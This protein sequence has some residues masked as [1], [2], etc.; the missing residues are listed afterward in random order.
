MK[1]QIIKIIVVYFLCGWVG[2][3]TAQQ[4]FK[5]YLDA[6]YFG[7]YARGFYSEGESVWINGVYINPGFEFDYKINKNIVVSP[8]MSVQFTHA[9]AIYEDTLKY[10]GFEA[11]NPLRLNYI[12]FNVESKYFFNPTWSIGLRYSGKFLVWKSIILADADVTDGFVRVRPGKY[13]D[14]WQN[15]LTLSLGYTYKDMEIRLGGGYVLDRIM[16]TKKD[17]P[18]GRKYVDCFSAGIKVSYVIFRK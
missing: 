16:D 3:L 13:T 12:S 9:K 15:E 4:A 2:S 10:F 11:K 17:S 7:M 14:R 5:S 6:G 8:G 1:H 18:L